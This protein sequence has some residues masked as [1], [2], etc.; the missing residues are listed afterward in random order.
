MSRLVQDQ[1]AGHRGPN[2]YS[3]PSQWL[4]TGKPVGSLEALMH[5]RSWGRACQLHGASACWLSAFHVLAGAGVSSQALCWLQAA[6][7]HS[8]TQGLSW[9]LLLIALKSTSD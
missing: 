1:T 3:S 4:E 6:Q 5:V 2:T 8:C 9:A 7:L